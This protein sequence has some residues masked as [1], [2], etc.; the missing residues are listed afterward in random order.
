MFFDKRLC[1][2]IYVIYSCSPVPSSPSRGMGL[3]LRDLPI[4]YPF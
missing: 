1:C 3:R 2:R 4:A